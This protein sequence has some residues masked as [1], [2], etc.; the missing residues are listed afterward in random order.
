MQVRLPPDTRRSFDWMLGLSS[1]G[2]LVAMAG[3]LATLVWWAQPWPAGVR[4]PCAIVTLMVT[5]T[6]AWG[7]WP[8]E[9]GGDRLTVWAGRLG[10][11]WTHERK[12]LLR[13]GASHGTPTPH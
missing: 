6:L 8:L 12:K 5:A 1:E 3:V 4:V 13:E 7:R 9:E 2:L 11:Y 10:R